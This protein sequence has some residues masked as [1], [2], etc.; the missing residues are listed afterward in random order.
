MFINSSSG[1][2]QTTIT[3]AGKIL[4]TVFWLS[5][6][7]SE[8]FRNQLIDFLAFVGAGRRVFTLQSPYA[9]YQTAFGNS[10]FQTVPWLA[11]LFAPFALMPIGQ[12]WLI[13]ISLN[14]SLLL[15]SIAIIGLTG[16]SKLSPLNFAY[17]LGCGS[18]VSYYCFAFGQ[19]TIFQLSILSTMIISLQ[20]NKRILAGALMPLALVKP[21]L[22]L[23]FIVSAF[24]IGGRRFVAS[25]ILATILFSAVAFIWQPQWPFDLLNTFISGQASSTMESW[26]FSTLTGLFSVSPSYGLLVLPLSFPALSWIRRKAG[27]LAAGSQLGIALAFSLA[28]S[29]YAFAYDLPLL[30]PALIWLSRPW[31]NLMAFIWTLLAAI[32]FFSGFSGNSYLATLITCVLIVRKLIM[33][34]NEQQISR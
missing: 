8:V 15:F 34:S 11:W 30:I 1:K 7:L 23:W 14:A 6:G 4:L 29:P 2:I 5:W 22:M 9:A 19:V 3:S 33:A 16:P 20:H 12:A 13:F 21:H 10:V 28:T 25:S 31:S 18:A 26:K 32:V 27:K 17:I 24:F